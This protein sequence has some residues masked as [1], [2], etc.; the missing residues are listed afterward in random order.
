MAPSLK[1]KTISRTFVRLCHCSALSMFS[2]ARFA[3]WWCI[4][5]RRLAGA[6]VERLA[7][8]A[9]IGTIV[10]RIDASLGKEGRKEEMA[11]RVD[12]YYH[13]KG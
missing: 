3:G 11:K 7:A 10:I 13:R 6:L 4:S 8:R 1:P 9:T 5:G 2:R 12:W